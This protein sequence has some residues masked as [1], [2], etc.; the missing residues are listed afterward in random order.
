MSKHSV[1]LTAIPAIPLV[2]PGDDLAALLIEALDRASL[3][4]GDHDV[5]L[6]F[7]TASFAAH[8]IHALMTAGSRTRTSP[9]D[10]GIYHVCHAREECLSLGEL[11]DTA[12]ECFRR[13]QGFRARGILPPLLG[14]ARAFELLAAGV[15]SFGG[16]VV[17]QGLRSVL[18]FARQLFT[19]KDIRNDRLVES[20]AG[21]RAPDPREI[22][23]RTCDYLVRTRWGR[24]IRHAV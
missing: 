10:H 2:R 18:P 22:A 7:V 23:A 11:V 13:D 19:H 4:P 12:F 21:Y 15:D 16:Q 8:A 20:Y 6:Y 3:V 17:N 14:D 5:P 1:N 9:S 24:R